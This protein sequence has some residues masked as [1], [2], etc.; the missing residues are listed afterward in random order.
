MPHA[1]PG[2]WGTFHT[3]VVNLTLP[4]VSTPPYYLMYLRVI[5]LAVL[6]QGTCF[7]YLSQIRCPILRRTS[8]TRVV[9]VMIMRASLMP[10]SLVVNNVYS[11]TVLF[12]IGSDQP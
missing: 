5:S 7:R 8:S 6:L 2:Q 11:I 4:Y 12:S 10:S 1:A 9:D 3:L